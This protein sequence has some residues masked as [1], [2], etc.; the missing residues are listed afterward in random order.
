[1]R[2]DFNY[3]MSSYE[4]TTFCREDNYNGSLMVEILFFSAAWRKDEDGKD[5]M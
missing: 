4:L 1:M 5:I 2:Q 3:N